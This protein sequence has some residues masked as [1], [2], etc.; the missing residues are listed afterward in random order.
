MNHSNKDK[1]SIILAIIEILSFLLIVTSI[2]CYWGGPPG[3][4]PTG[5]IEHFKLF[6]YRSDFLSILVAFSPLIVFFLSLVGIIGGWRLF[7]R[8][9]GK[10]E[11]FIIILSLV[12]LGLSFFL[13]WLLFGL[14]RGL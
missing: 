6:I 10:F 11:L 8:K 7:K 13:G 12:N 2:V 4:H 5:L 1:K 14:A 9:K 3:I